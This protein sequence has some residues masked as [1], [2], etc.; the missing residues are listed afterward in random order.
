M[1]HSWGFTAAE[2]ARASL[3]MYVLRLRQVRDCLEEKE[4]RGE[5]NTAPHYSLLKHLQIYVILNTIF[6]F[7][8]FSFGSFC[9]LIRA[10]VFVLVI[11]NIQHF[12]LFDHLSV[13]SMSDNQ[14][15]VWSVFFQIVVALNAKKMIR[16]PETVAC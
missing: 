4:A 13:S 15:S 1:S 6:V 2:T 9:C 16:I 3:R 10:L 12:R 5:I 14:N 11:R 8:I 7:K